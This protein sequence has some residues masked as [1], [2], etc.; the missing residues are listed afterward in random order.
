MFSILLYS[1]VSSCTFLPECNQSFI[2]YGVFALEDID[3]GEFILEYK[4]DLIME[5]EGCE[6]EKKYDKEKKGSFLYFFSFH[7]KNYWYVV[8]SQILL[9]IV[10]LPFN[11]DGQVNN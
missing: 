7:S 2:G 1:R 5:E 9:A 3:V 6:R 8:Y 10:H 11:N 4:G